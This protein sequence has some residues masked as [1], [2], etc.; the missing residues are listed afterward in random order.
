M[1]SGFCRFCETSMCMSTACV[2]STVREGF[3]ASGR[4]VHQF[5]TCGTSITGVMSLNCRSPYIVT[6]LSKSLEMQELQ[7]FVYKALTSTPFTH[8]VISQ[9]IM[10]CFGGC[11]A[12]KDASGARGALV[13]Q[14]RALSF[15]SKAVSKHCVR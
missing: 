15:F 5:L 11:S 13:K 8:V 1:E 6:P 14:N 10:N 4:S 2:E 3:D 12:R 7:G 9:E